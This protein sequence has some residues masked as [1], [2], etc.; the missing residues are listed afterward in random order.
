MGNKYSQTKEAREKLKSRLLDYMIAVHGTEPDHYFTK[1]E[2]TAAVGCSERAVRHELEKI[3]NYY[4]IIATSERKG[5]RIFLLDDSID[6]FN[7]NKAR[8]DID[9]T[10]AELQSR[11]LSL[12]A[13]MYP[14]IAARV[15][16]GKALAKK[17]ETK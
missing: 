13:R 7:L 2:L 4:P 16:I 10:L 17:K 8:A 3:A 12:Q 6:E 11:V 1:D 15:E 5:Y 14:L 9:H